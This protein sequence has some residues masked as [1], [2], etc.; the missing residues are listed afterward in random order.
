[1]DLKTPQESEEVA[2]ARHLTWTRNGVAVPL[3]SIVTLDESAFSTACV[4]ACK[5][6]ARLVSL[7]GLRAMSEDM[8]ILAALVDDAE[9]R[10]G[11]CMARLTRDPVGGGFSMKS[12]T[13]ELPQAQ[14]FER[15]LFED[16]GVQPVGHPWLKPLRRHESLEKRAGRLDVAPP[17][18]F[19]EV[20]GEGIH[21]V[22][23]GPV[24]A[25][26]IEPGHF[27]F[28]CEGETVLHLEIQLGYQSRGAESLFLRSAAARRLPSRN[29]SRAIRPSGTRRPTA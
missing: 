13:R 7:V 28:Q 23:V 18:A 9:G 2:P 5:G 22:A 27:R 21:E 15:A 11:L 3:D 4:D 24:H 17:H 14:A 8:R 19:F 25:G 20:R 16:H 12:L 1:M 26:V 6:G 10:I 29:V